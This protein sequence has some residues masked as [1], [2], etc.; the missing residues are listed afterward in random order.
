[1]M[2]E[3]I[4]LQALRPQRLQ[5]QTPFQQV[6][7]KRQ[8]LGFSGIVEYLQLMS[9]LRHDP[10]L[11]LGGQRGLG[12]V[13]WVDLFCLKRMDNGF[14]GFASGVAHFITPL[15][16]RAGFDTT[17]QQWQRDDLTPKCWIS[18]WG[19]VMKKY[20]EQAE[21]SVIIELPLGEQSI[22]VKWPTSVPEGCARFVRGLAM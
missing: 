14:G 7:L 17:Q 19:D 1:M 9:V 4:Q 3:A 2:T 16:V 21:A 5:A 6:H 20:T 13:L 12:G 18:T 8:C 22:T 11:E 15:V 10:R